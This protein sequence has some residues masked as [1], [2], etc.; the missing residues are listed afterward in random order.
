MASNTI[1]YHSFEKSLLVKQLILLGLFSFPLIL[2]YLFSDIRASIF[3]AIFFPSFIGFIWLSW[4]IN[5][6]INALMRVVTSS[7][8]NINAKDYASQPY[9]PYKKGIVYSFKHEINHLNHELE[10]IN[11]GEKQAAFILFQL[12]EQ[13]ETPILIF[14]NRQLLIR[15]N[16][17]S[18]Q[19]LSGSWQ[20]FKG[21]DL[22]QL[23]LQKRN[24]GIECVDQTHKWA[25]K[26]SFSSNGSDEYC[27]VLIQN[28][29][30]VVNHTEM[31]A[32]HRLI[33]VIGHEVRNSLT[34]IYSLSK[35]IAEQIPA[36]D[37]KHQALNVIIARS[38]GLQAFIK[39]TTELT[40]IPT[41]SPDWL[42]TQQLLESC[43]QLLPNIKFTLQVSVKQVY[44][45]QTLIEQ[46][47][48]N[49]I[50]NADEAMIDKQP[51]L[52]FAQAKNHGVEIKISDKGT[53][54]YDVNNLFVPFYTTKEHGSGIGLVISKQIISAHGGK[55]SIVN[56]KN[57]LGVTANIWLPT[58]A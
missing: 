47:L 48:I 6:K 21:Q 38:Q 49:I 10:K 35:V 43:L 31:H 52:I 39:N 50:K 18:S 22:N 44:A 30:L 53:G 14:D 46:V 5:H 58:P 54:V 42:D 26:S 28:I 8:E 19:F 40:N 27:L 24:G 11:F 1:K 17:S 25:V 37:E 33:R 29:E 55:I 13:L 15:A 12:I 20:D 23:G 57:T 16:P 56:N 41:P 2:C 45:D 4:H 9:L 3:L 51:V 34:P 32:W 7:I 36:D